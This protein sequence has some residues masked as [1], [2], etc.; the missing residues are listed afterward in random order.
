MPNEHDRA[1][2]IDKA[3]FLIDLDGS[4][5]IIKTHGI[6]KFHIPPS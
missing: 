1:L 6:V 4:Q 5:P 2:P 3:P